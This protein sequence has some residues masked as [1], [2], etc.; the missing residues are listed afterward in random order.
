[1][2][3]DIDTRTEALPGYRLIEMIGR[4]GFGE[5]W[6]VEAPGGL[7]KACK[8]IHGRIV[9]GDDAS[10]AKVHRE[11]KGLERLKS[12]RHPFILTLERIDVVDGQ[13]VVIMELADRDLEHRLR[14]VKESGLCGIPRPELMKYLV[15]M[16][17]ALDVMNV[18]YDIQHLDIKPSNIFLVRGHVK[19]ADFGLSKGIEGRIGKIS[20]GIT[21][22]YAAP[23]TFDGWV[24]RHTDQY[25][26][27]ILYQEMLTGARPFPGPSPRQLMVQHMTGEPDLSA[28]PECDRPIVRKALSK[29]PDDRYENCSQFAEALLAAEA[30]GIE[31]LL[32]AARMSVS[33]A[34]TQALGPR[35]P[36]GQVNKETIDGLPGKISTVSIPKPFLSPRPAT[37]LASGRSLP[38]RLDTATAVFKRI[39]VTSALQKVPAFRRVGRQSEGRPT[40]VLGLGQLGGQVIEAVQKRLGSRPDQ[41]IGDSLRFLWF[42]CESPKSAT[43]ARSG[44]LVDCLVRCP[45]PAHVRVEQSSSAAVGEGETRARRRLG[46]AA[47]LAHQTT[48]RHRLRLELGNI[49]AN[50]VAGGAASLSTPR[51]VLIASMGGGT[52]G[53]MLVDLAYGVQQIAKSL[54]LEPLEIECVLVAG[55]EPNA[56]LAE[57]R[58]LNHYA[59]AL[60]LERF[61]EPNAKHSVQTDTGEQTLVGPM[62]RA[63]Y[64]LNAA[65]VEQA[66]GSTSKLPQ[67][68]GDFLIETAAGPIGR[69]LRQME[70]EESWPIFRSFGTA[71]LVD[72]ELKTARVVAARLCEATFAAWSSPLSEAD[73][74]KI[75]RAIGE[76]WYEANVAA[77][78]VV[79][80]LKLAANEKFGRNVDTAIAQAL[81]L[82]ETSLSH[83]PNTDLS[84]WCRSSVNRLR[85]LLDPE[86]EPDRPSSWVGALHAIRPTVAETIRGRLEG[87]VDRA[88]IGPAARLTAIEA[89]RT[90]LGSMLDQFLVEAERRRQAARARLETA[91]EALQEFMIRAASIPTRVVN[92][93][94]RNLL[95]SRAGGSNQLAPGV[96]AFATGFITH[97]CEHSAAFVEEHLESTAIECYREI[98][99]LW[100]ERAGKAHH[101]SAQIELFAA[102]LGSSAAEIELPAVCEF[103]SSARSLDEAAA[104]SLEALQVDGLGPFEQLLDAAIESAGGMQAL[105]DRFDK[106]GPTAARGVLE[107]TEK[108]VMQHLGA[109]DVATR[110]L[111]RLGADP[112]SGNESLRKLFQ[113]ASPSALQ[114]DADD[115]NGVR[116]AVLVSAPAEPAASKLVE[117][118]A[119]ACSVNAIAVS[120]S[121]DVDMVRVSSS[122]SLR[123]MLPEWI[124]EGA[125]NF[126]AARRNDDAPELFG[127]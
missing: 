33:A 96:G 127:N 8:F 59:L 125:A 90:S 45:L 87:A 61:I 57:T 111:D 67:I 71:S 121:V 13:L 60:D 26:L 91:V 35:E 28:L 102:T 16:A 124:W 39:D 3:A 19:V 93:P 22:I 51:A 73:T 97:L 4:G 7:Q 27:A 74:V 30:G 75:G 112:K 12:V 106:Q 108:Y 15:E 83:D 20:G 89:A 104:R 109:G 81:H 123:P 31:K 55:V 14:E 11:L 99:S 80:E 119:A 37:P 69:R 88:S 38:P 18:D 17:E 1:M 52:G 10:G 58:K 107:T 2:A 36:G 94:F 84:D 21:P 24:S 72:P 53:G 115:A 43:G 46:R 85:H 70:L 68:L 103:S 110:F 49:A 6:K 47:F 44:A 54:A 122:T 29:K 117:A 98:V 65:K 56:L 114:T 50:S 66:T 118:I 126:E 34:G 116:Q 42:D 120:G 77:A 5:V 78:N 95:K 100:K 23:E 92:K 113:A 25:S 86:N 48:I 40:L 62:A 82:I 63:V 79:S 32:Q 64:F 41:V 76:R 9:A 105:L 101:R